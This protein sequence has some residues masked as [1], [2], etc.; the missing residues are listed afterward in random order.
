VQRSRQRLDGGAA[1]E[2]YLTRSFPGQIKPE[3]A[4][5][6][7]NPGVVLLVTSVASLIRHDLLALSW[8]IRPG[9]ASWPLA[10]VPTLGAAA[11]MVVMA[12][13][14]RRW[15][16]ARGWDDRHPRPG[17]RGVDLPRPRRGLILPKTTADHVGV[18]GLNLVLI[19]LLILHAGA[20]RKGLPSALWGP[21]KKFP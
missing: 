12:W 2:T 5:S 3:L 8:R 17:Q 13:L 15:S 18:A 10:L 1:I 7:P 19:A 20:W 21:R 9:F 6:A 11:V 14:L 4:T 16:V